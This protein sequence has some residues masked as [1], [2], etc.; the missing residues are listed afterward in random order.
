MAMIYKGQK[1]FG[2]SAALSCFAIISS[3]ACTVTR[4]D[5]RSFTAPGISCEKYYH[6]EHICSKA[7]ER[8]RS[9][10]TLDM[11]TV[12]DW[13]GVDLINNTHRGIWGL[14]LGDNV[15]TTDPTLGQGD[16]IIIGGPAENSIG[17]L[18]ESNKS[19]FRSV[20]F[21]IF[22]MKM[23]DG[24]Y[25]PVVSHLSDW[26][27]FT[28]TNRAQKIT[29]KYEDGV[30]FLMTNNSTE[31]EG[32]LD[33]K[34]VRD[35]N[36]RAVVDHPGDDDI[37]KIARKFV[38]L[39]TFMQ[40]LSAHH[41]DMIMVI[42]V[43]WGKAMK[44]QRVLNDPT[45][46]PCYQTQAPELAD[47]RNTCIGFWDLDAPT[48]QE[49]VRNLIRE[50]MRIAKSIRRG[51]TDGPS[52]LANIIFKVPQGVVPEPAILETFLHAYS[53]LCDP[54]M[55][56][57]NTCMRQALWAPQPDAGG[58]AP[59]EGT[60]PA[61]AVQP[62][63]EGWIGFMG[64]K[65]LNLFDP[66]SL[67]EFLVQGRGIAFW[68]TSIHSPRH[69]QGQPIAIGSSP[70]GDLDRH[71]LRNSLCQ[72]IETLPPYDDRP[73]NWPACENRATDY[74]DLMDYLKVIS[75]RRS[76]IWV[77]DPAGPL[78]RHGNYGMSWAQYGNN[79]NDHRGD[80]QESMAYKWG[81]NAVYTTDRPMTALIIRSILKQRYRQT[82]EEN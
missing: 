41:S 33:K 77:I 44:Q 82:E 52:M 31:F 23:A 32:D 35:R 20:E 75:N 21:D 67:L 55:I 78:G 2:L 64:A 48:D 3:A 68:D 34:N 11:F 19:G 30:G 42:D 54:H 4:D 70:L 72:M 76:A 29:K 27:G 69:W 26:R 12:V 13:D 28:N 49:Q 22:P 1:I 40:F 58:G 74:L 25:V 9:C 71:R 51:G 17:G 61:K 16:E 59:F 56:S 45:E 43:K 36:G 65:N 62:Y 80:I 47:F 73:I 57:N 5:G 53:D 63:V 18:V 6:D 7:A 14:T 15:A 60:D 24:R 8:P 66:E 39:K 81:K 10:R 46:D 50:C 79:Y 37:T 38:T